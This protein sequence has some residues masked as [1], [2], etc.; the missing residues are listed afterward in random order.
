MVIAARRSDLMVSRRDRQILGLALRK[1]GGVRFDFCDAL[2]AVREATEELIPNG[3][4]FFLG[5]SSGPM[6]GSII[7]RVGIVE[8][9]TG[10]DLVWVAHGCRE[11][12]RLGRFG[13]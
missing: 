12:R 8:S 10:I 5:A 7:S 9:A 3:R 4:V 11:A 6:F 2:F 13:R 1:L